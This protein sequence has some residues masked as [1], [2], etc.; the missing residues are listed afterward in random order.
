MLTPG[1]GWAPLNRY[2]ARS[3]RFATLLAWADEST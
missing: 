1:P 2:V 3:L